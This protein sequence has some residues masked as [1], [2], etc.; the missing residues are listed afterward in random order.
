MYYRYFEN[1]EPRPSHFGI[2][3]K[4]HK[5]IY[6][7]GLANVGDSQRW[8]FYDLEKDPYENTNQYDAV[9]GSGLIRDLKGQ[10]SRLQ[11]EADDRP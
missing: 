2:R 10:L 5:L 6:Y 4:Q 11:T 3:T 9:A 8:E 7:D 1:S